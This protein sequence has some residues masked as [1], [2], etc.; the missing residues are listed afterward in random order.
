MSLDSRLLAVAGEIPSGCHAD[1]GSDHAKLPIYLL[2]QKICHKVIVT[3]LS[4]LAFQV[5]RRALWGREAE[6]RLGDGLRPLGQGEAS[7]VSLCGMG[8][9]L[10]VRILTQEPEKVP[11]VVVTQANR[12]SF[13]VR[14]WALLFGFHLAKE[15]LIKGSRVFEVLTFRRRPGPDP[16]YCSVP[17]DLALHFGPLLLREG[18]PLLYEEVQR[19]LRLYREHPLNQDLSRLKQALSFIAEQSKS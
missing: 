8:G 15:Q 12:D 18:N 13:K 7:S 14:Q 9:S 16:A 19:R 5:A 4:R 2:E 17:L 10:V 3:E 11:P 1:V 6:V